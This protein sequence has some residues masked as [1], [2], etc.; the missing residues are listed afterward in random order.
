MSKTFK[1]LVLDADGVF[2]HSSFRFGKMLIEERGFSREEMSEFW[3]G[4]FRKCMDGTL[5]LKEV[6]VP[7]LNKWGWEEGVDAF[8]DQWYEMEAN[9][10]EQMI[11]FLEQT[12]SK[13]IPCYMASNQEKYRAAYFRE[14]FSFL[15]YF[16]KVFFSSEL[17]HAKPA[18][19]YYHLITEDLS[20]ER[21]DILF[22]DDTARHVEAARKY[23]W[24]ANKYTSFEPF[25]LAMEEYT[26]SGIA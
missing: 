25:S 16:K 12:A 3:S 18:I 23:G 11:A 24:Q 22:W 6:L 13:G 1:A 7:Y 15:K 8:I 17:G 4:P 10:D 20:L 14:H 21:K 19:V 26:Y 9:I 2:V 5:D